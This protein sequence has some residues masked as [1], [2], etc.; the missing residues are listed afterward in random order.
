MT[1]EKK[2][3]DG[4]TPD[5]ANVPEVKQSEKF[6][7]LIQYLENRKSRGVLEPAGEQM[8]LDARRLY[9]EAKIDEAETVG[10]VLRGMEEY[11]Q[12]LPVSPAAKIANLVI[13]VIMIFFAVCMA[14]SFFSK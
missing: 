9:A 14:I 7:C 5:S 11:H 6:A 3:E 1:D 12:T 2:L 13:W 8:L 4:V 10:D